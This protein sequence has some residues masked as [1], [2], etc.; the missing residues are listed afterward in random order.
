MTARCVGPLDFLESCSSFHSMAQ[1]PCTA[2]TGSP[3]DGRVSGGSAW[4][5]RKM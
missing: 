2:P 1:K 4:K 3:S 5:A